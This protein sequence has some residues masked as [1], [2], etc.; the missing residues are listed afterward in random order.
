LIGIKVG[1]WRLL[2]GNK[3]FSV[4]DGKQ[5]KPD[6]LMALV[7]EHGP[8]LQALAHQYV[9]G[10]GLEPDDLVQETF[11]ALAGLE[12]PPG[13]PKTWLW[14]TLRNLAISARRTKERQ[15]R[16]E[17]AVRFSQSADFNPLDQ[18]IKYEVSGVLREMIFHLPENE[19]ELLVAINWGGLT[20]TEAAEV[21]AIPSSTLHRRYQAVLALLKKQLGDLRND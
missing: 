20:F 18:I 2:I 7:E 11:L 3:F 4:R 15:G 19:R 13:F 14:R 1:L 16:R 5:L 17:R 21:L 8:W 12:S 6:P 9:F 10:T